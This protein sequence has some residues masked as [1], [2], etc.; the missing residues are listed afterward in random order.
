MEQKDWMALLGLAAAF[1]PVVANGASGFSSGTGTAGAAAAGGTAPVTPE[2]A[3]TA[4]PTA[5]GMLTGGGATSASPT[6]AS[7]PS[8]TAPGAAVDSRS[9][10]EKLGNGAQ[11]AFSSQA[12]NDRLNSW[13]GGLSS[14]SAQGNQNQQ[15]L[16]LLRQMGYRV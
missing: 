16:M 9:F 14:G 4:A 6:T 1:S 8:G 15:Q 2:N 12:Y 3:G 11:N 5:T 7:V 13:T 10:W